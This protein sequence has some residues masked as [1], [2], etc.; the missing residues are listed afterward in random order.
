[1]SGLKHTVLAIFFSLVCS[2]ALASKEGALNF[3]SFS[4]T[5]DGIGESGKITISG[6]QTDAEGITKLTI[7]A[8]GKTIIVPADKLAELNNIGVN[9]IHMSYD[10][11][12]IIFLRLT[13]GAVLGGMSGKIIEIKPSGKIK[14]RE[15]S[16]NE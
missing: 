10:T 3:D 12:K 2:N 13:H 9:Q 6:K 4:V 7:I 5:S 8:F 1:M 11:A 16:K 15:I 14:I